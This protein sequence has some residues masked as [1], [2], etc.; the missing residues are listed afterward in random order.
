[1]IFLSI[2]P[3]NYNKPI[4]SKERKQNPNKTFKKNIKKQKAT[5]TT[6]IKMLNNCI[7]SGKHIYLLSYMEGCGPCNAT[8]PEWSKIRNVLE[9]KYK[10]KYNDIVVV[11]IDHELLKY[12]SLKINPAGFP[13][14]KYISKKGRHIQDYEE[15]D[16][17]SKNRSVDSFIEWIETIIKKNSSSYSNKKMYG[18]FVYGKTRKN[19]M[20][21]TRSSN[22]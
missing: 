2:N 11:D 9:E 3:D 4:S 12:I 20:S 16:I 5:M 14:M 8:R 15:A 18:G 21:S 13:S 7:K 19:K 1:M 6:P 10:N 22:R 17:S